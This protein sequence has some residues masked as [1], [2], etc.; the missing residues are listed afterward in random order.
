MPLNDFRSIY[1]PYCI[2][3]VSPGCFVVLNREYMPLGFN[4]KRD[5][6]YNELPII[7][8]IKGLTPATIKKLAYNGEMRDNM[9]FLYNDGLIPTRSAENMR[10]YLE[11]LAILAKYKVE[12]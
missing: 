6:S 9:I 10:L 8:K 2:K 1:F 12:R 3:K 7:A 5:V 4:E 11:K